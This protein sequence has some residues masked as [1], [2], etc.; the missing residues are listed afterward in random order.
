MGR[1]RRRLRSGEVGAWAG[2]VESLIQIISGRAES[3]FNRGELAPGFFLPRVVIDE[4]AFSIWPGMG[5]CDGRG[6]GEQHG[7]C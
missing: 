7:C 2:P 1:W 3:G 6:F 5:G 4:I